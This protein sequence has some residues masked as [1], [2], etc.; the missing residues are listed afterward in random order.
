MISWLFQLTQRLS[1]Y[2]SI[3]FWFHKDVFIY[4]LSHFHCLPFV[5]F[6]FKAF[7]VPVS[8]TEGISFL[9]L[10]M[11]LWS[12]LLV[13]PF[14]KHTHCSSWTVH[15]LNVNE[16]ISNMCGCSAAWQCEEHHSAVWESHRADRRGG[17]RCCGSSEAVLQ[18]F[19]RREH[20]QVA[21]TRGLI[22]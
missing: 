11:L 19:G 7:H 18:Q 3:P 10:P 14:S 16:L 2:L 4:Y 17:R 1:F 6:Y 9:L 21:V 22:C 15:S 12:F 5:N 8:P 13:L 20:G